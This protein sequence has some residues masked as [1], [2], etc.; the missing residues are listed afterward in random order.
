METGEHGT[1][2]ARGAHAG[3]H[4]PL[5]WFSFDYGPGR[6]YAA[7]PLGFALLN[8]VL[9]IF[10]L[11]KIIWPALRDGA[12]RRHRE[13]ARQLDEAKKIHEEA[14]ARLTEYGR[15]MAE[16]E[17]EIGRVVASI[18]R[19]AEAERDRLLAAAA[20]QA[21]RIRKDAEFTIAQELKQARIDLE[22]EVVRAAIS[23]AETT[24]RATANAQDDRRL[25]QDLVQRLERLEVRA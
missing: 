1:E 25:A 5:N 17:Q 23:A 7:P 16:I 24:L 4:E 19:D 12:A 18:R 20:E 14:E 10:L 6:H 21:E 8:F 13:I 11:K 9:L 15:R 2:A 22:R 3:A